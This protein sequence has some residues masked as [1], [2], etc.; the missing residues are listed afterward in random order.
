MVATVL[1]V[2]PLDGG[3]VIAKP[4]DITVGI[5]GSASFTFQAGS[6][7]GVYR[8]RLAGGLMQTTVHFVVTDKKAT[9]SSN[10]AAEGS[11]P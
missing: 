9:A 8:V 10:P 1:S 3:A 6:I 2:S 5:D 11:K 7:P 4:Q